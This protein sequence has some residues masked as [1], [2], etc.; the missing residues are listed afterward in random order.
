MAVIKCG[1]H[2]KTFEI[3]NW[4]QNKNLLWQRTTWKT[5]IRVRVSDIFYISLMCEKNIL[6]SSVNMYLFMSLS[7]M[8]LHIMGKLA[9]RRLQQHTKLSREFSVQCC[10]YLYGKCVSISRLLFEPWHI[11]HNFPN[12]KKRG[13][14]NAT[15]HI[16]SS[17]NYESEQ[18]SKWQ[19]P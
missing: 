7:A 19:R 12:W 8:L 6:V 1:R 14:G 5:H 18:V 11:Y 16:F 10:L 17:I 3:R 2:L 15:T 13:N 4:I 9:R